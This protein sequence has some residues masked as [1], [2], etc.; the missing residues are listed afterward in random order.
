MNI[1]TPILQEQ[2]MTSLDFLNI[3]INP[4]RLA[5]GENKVRNNEF[6]K[7]VVDEIDDLV[8]YEK[9]VR[10]NIVLFANLTQD[11]MMLVG[12]RESK[13][14]RK[15]VQAKIK[16]FEYITSPSAI[17]GSMN[18]AQLGLLTR[19]VQQREITEKQL[20]L[21]RKEKQRIQL[22]LPNLANDLRKHVVNPDSSFAALAVDAPSDIGKQLGISRVKVITALVDCGLMDFN[23]DVPDIVSVSGLGRNDKNGTSRWSH[24]LISYHPFR[25]SLGLI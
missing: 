19:E 10:G 21:E 12:M 8:T 1:Q 16:E 17:L 13:A 18:S 15:K 24:L 7:K 20:E 6:M 22:S 3:I 14:V 25:K 9:T 2:T 23:H 4:A 11:Q 5:E